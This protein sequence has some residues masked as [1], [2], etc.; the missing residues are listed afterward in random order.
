MAGHAS[1][2]LSLLGFFFAF[3]FAT[4]AAGWRARRFARLPAMPAA[5]DDF[6][7]GAPIG[8]FKL[9]MPGRLGFG[10]SAHHPPIGVTHQRK[11]SLQYALMAERAQQLGEAV[12][13]ATA[14]VGGRKD[15]L[16]GAGSE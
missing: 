12:D 14:A 13:L 15:G 8:E 7:L 10:K 4:L 1:E 6:R 5:A 3:A 2:Q 16:A 11:A 9:D